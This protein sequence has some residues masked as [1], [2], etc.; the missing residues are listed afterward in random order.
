[1]GTIIFEGL[2]T[3]GLVVAHTASAVVSGETVQL[4]FYVYVDGNPQR[5]AS[6]HVPMLP[7]VAEKLIAELQA[8]VVSARTHFQKS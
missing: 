4:T 2:S 5:P 1:M 7:D 8:A 6:I 3:P